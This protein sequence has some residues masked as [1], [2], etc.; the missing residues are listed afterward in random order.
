VVPLCH[1]AHPTVKPF[2]PAVVLRMPGI[3]GNS[4][5]IAGRHPHILRSTAD[6]T[7]ITCGFCRMH[8]LSHSTVIVCLHPPRSF[9]FLLFCVNNFSLFVFTGLFPDRSTHSLHRLTR[10]FETFSPIDSQSCSYRSGVF[11]RGGLARNES[12]RRLDWKTIP[13][14]CLGLQDI[15]LQ[16]RPGVLGLLGPNGAGKSTLMRILATVTRPTRGRVLWND[17]DVLSSPDPL[18]T[19]LGYLPQDFIRISPHS[20]SGI[21]R[22]RQRS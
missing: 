20:N 1:P 21:P 14:K 22:R 5:G 18:R 7:T 19:V 4:P 11:S 3:L 17:A 13:W 6:R 9:L 15:S 10:S 12:P 8:S 2:S 16:L